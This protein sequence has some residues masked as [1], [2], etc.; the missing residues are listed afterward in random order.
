MIME[1]IQEAKAGF[2][3]LTEAIDTTTGH[4]R[5]MMQIDGRGSRSLATPPDFGPYSGLSELEA[6]P[7]LITPSLNSLEGRLPPIFLFT[8]SVQF[9]R[10][11]I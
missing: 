11:R 6:P 1:R 4:G 3:S 8:N 7:P 10:N 5:M 9:Y 2:R